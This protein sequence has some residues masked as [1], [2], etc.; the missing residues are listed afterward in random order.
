[1]PT[2]GKKVESKIKISQ[3][4]LQVLKERVFLFE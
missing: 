2:M 4:G 1:M 3:K